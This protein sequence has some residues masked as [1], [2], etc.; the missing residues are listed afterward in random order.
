MAINS[1]LYKSFTNFLGLD[2]RSSD[3]LRQKGA[4]TAMLNADFRD[5]GA[6]NKRKGYK[7]RSRYDLGASG[8]ISNG[9]FTFDNVDIDTG[10]ATEEIIAVGK[11][12]FQLKEETM[13]I[14]HTPSGA[15]EVPSFSI[16][17]NETTNVMEFILYEDGNAVSTIGLG[18]GRGAGDKIISSLVTDISAVTRFSC[19]AS[20]ASANEKAAFLPTQTDVAFT[21]NTATFTASYWSKVSVPSGSSLV[22]FNTHY[23]KM[24]QTD[25]ENCSF[26]ELLNVCYI[27]NGY[28]NLMKY[29]GNRCYRAGLPQATGVTP[30]NGT[31]GTTFTAGQ[32]AYYRA[33][34]EYTDAKGNIITGQL[35]SNQKLTVTDGGSGGRNALNINVDTVSATSGFNTDQGVVYLNQSGVNT[36]NIDAGHAF[37]VDDYVYLDDGVSGEIVSRRITATTAT[38]ITIDG[39]AVN[40]LD[41]EVISSV[42]VS[43]YRNGLPAS[44]SV[45][46][47]LQYLVDE[48]VNNTGAGALA[49]V[50]STLDR[51]T[52]VQLIEPISPHALPPKGKY[53]SSWRGQLLIAGKVDSVTSVYYSDVD[54][55]EYFPTD[56][57][58][59]VNT[60][61]TGIGTLDNILF[62]FQDHAISGVTGDLSER[63]ISVNE[64]SREG[65]GCSAHHTIQE[66]QG[67]MWFLSA[68]G[69]FS[70]DQQGLRE[71]SSQIKPKFGPTNPFSFKQAVAINSTKD[72]KYILCM[73][74]LTNASGENLASDDVDSEVYVFDY[75]RGAWLEWN[76]FNFM[77][78][79][80]IFNDNLYFL[81]KLTNSVSTVK[82]DSYLVQVSQQNTE[83]DYADHEIATAF[84][85]STHWEA[86]QDPSVWKKFLRL[87]MHAL[88]TSINTFESDSFTLVASMQHD[89][90]LDTVAS[91]TIDYSGGALG[92]GL[93]PWGQF[94][95]GEP[96]L[97]SAKKKLAS[98]K[99][100]S[101]RL[102]FTNSVAHEN[103]LI[104]GYEL[105]L[106]TP[107]QEGMKE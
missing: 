10:T 42:K 58:F 83:Y 17:L 102:T 107:Y 54:S 100:K 80:T 79:I 15:A 77:G 103:I 96:R 71:E 9:I 2:L 82:F 25:F 38:S 21:S 45:S 87:K 24:A 18:T 78:G 69:V 93:G 76:R 23:G 105:Q 91:V 29:D 48:K 32:I 41:N 44:S 61:V 57:E 37:Q 106:V 65:I 64:V 90:K 66:V 98:K 51:T 33:V 60:A 81:Q 46:T 55:P 43:L 34:Y 19:S 85:Y 3:L 26:Q 53:L 95:W 73:P 31:D 27:S 36:I 104:S 99:V 6:L 101:H 94:P 39:A 4:A 14:T 1:Q 12:L 30:T 68:E 84:S 59:K 7:I 20:S 50:D 92:W 63:N 88:D 47:D 86:L 75:F 40:V 5:T 13:T 74:K 67:R 22:P 62:V 35:S 89:Y 56:N 52:A 70:M 72:D 8:V 16:K 28:D 49:F 11:D 97:L